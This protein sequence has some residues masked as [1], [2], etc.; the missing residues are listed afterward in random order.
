MLFSFLFELRRDE[1]YFST[2]IEPGLCMQKY[3]FFHFSK[4]NLFRSLSLPL[5]IICRV[6]IGRFCHTVVVASDFV[7]VCFVVCHKL[8]VRVRALP[9]SKKDMPTTIPTTISTIP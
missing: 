6:G 5:T 8:D 1:E 4:N 9:I 3:V 7:A 2:F